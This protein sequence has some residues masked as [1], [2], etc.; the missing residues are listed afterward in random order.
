MP[1][2]QPS[3]TDDPRWSI[4]GNLSDRAIA[5]LARLLLGPVEPDAPSEDID[6]I[7]IR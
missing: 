1:E 4:V 5:A 6:P 7:S 2:P 3:S